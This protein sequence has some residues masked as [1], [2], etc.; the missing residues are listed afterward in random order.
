MASR[1]GG[2]RRESQEAAASSSRE[3]PIC[4]PA[5][6]RPGGGRRK[7]RVAAVS[8]SITARDARVASHV[9]D[10]PRV[11]Q[12]A[13][14]LRD[15]ADAPPAICRP[16]LAGE[17]TMGLARRWGPARP[18][19]CPVS[20]PPLCIFRE[21]RAARRGARLPTASQRGPRPRRWPL[22]G[23]PSVW[24]KLSPIQLD[25]SATVIAGAPS[26]L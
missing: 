16:T 26:R 22:P 4:P 5:A 15:H 1:V 3:I 17:P 13:G 18:R 12:V 7:S 24:S 14:V 8:S 23:K 11:S 21:R 20:Y 19:G 2:G 10:P 25:N 6:P 9:V